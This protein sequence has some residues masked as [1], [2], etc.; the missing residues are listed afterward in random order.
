MKKSQKN[1]NIINMKKKLSYPIYFCVYIARLPNVQLPVRFASFFIKS[2][3][4][5]SGIGYISLLIPKK[6]KTMIVDRY[7]IIFVLQFVW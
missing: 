7:M 5:Y 6:K 2:I 4:K 3:L 1:F